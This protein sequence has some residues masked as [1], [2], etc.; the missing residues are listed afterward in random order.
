MN[1]CTILFRD[2]KFI[3]NQKLVNDYKAVARFEK[4]MF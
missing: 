4:L 3:V 1:Y 2:S